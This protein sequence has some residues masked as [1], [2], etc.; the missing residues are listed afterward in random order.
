MRI[1]VCCASR[2][3]PRTCFRNVFVFNLS[4]KE[5]VV[6]VYFADAKRPFLVSNETQLESG[7]LPRGLGPLT[8]SSLD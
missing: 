7:H 6:K 5:P 3:E 1:N 4:G 8:R 2:E